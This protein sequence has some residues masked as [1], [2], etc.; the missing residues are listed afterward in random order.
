MHHVASMPTSEL[1]SAFATPL[2]ATPSAQTNSYR[3]TRSR[4]GSTRPCTGCAST[5]PAGGVSALCFTILSL[6]S[7][8]TIYGPDDVASSYSA[9][10]QLGRP[11]RSRTNIACYSPTGTPP[12][13]TSLGAVQTESDYGTRTPPRTLCTRRVAREVL[14]GGSRRRGIERQ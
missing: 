9:T 1:L 5:S 2:E 13:P 8:R 11:G 14:H 7:Q 10:L 12:G 3:T 6:T 4:R